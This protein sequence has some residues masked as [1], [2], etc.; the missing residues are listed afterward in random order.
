MPIPGGL[1]VSPDGTIDLTAYNG[2]RSSI[3]WIDSRNNEVI[4]TGNVVGGTAGIIVSPGIKGFDAPPYTLSI[5]EL[6]AQDGAAFRSVR[7]TARELFVPL[8]LWAPTRGQL[9][10]LK[11]DLVSRL[12]PKFGKGIL[13][14]VETDDFGVLSARY[15][16]CYYSSGMEGDEQDAGQF[17]YCNFG[18]ILKAVNPWWYGNPITAGYNLANIT[19]VNFFTGKAKGVA[20]NFLPF[21]GLSNVWLATGAP[22]TITIA[23][24]VETWPV[25]TI[26]G[27]GGAQFTLSNLT[28]GKSLTLN[29]DFTATGDTVT[30]DTRP[31]VKTAVNSAN[32]NVWQYFGPNPKLWEFLPGDNQVSFALTLAGGATS[33]NISGNVSFTY[34]PRY[35]GA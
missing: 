8:F 34:R 12:I 25:W 30:I 20:G 18:L 28:T 27:K 13:K 17:T 15:I 11:R 23:G 9:V 32:A 31:G 10:N 1:S 16:D 7:A 6:P 26:T 4:L 22:Q 33:A 14:V 35:S 29:Y 19:P 24:D 5:D 21:S 2:V 3:S